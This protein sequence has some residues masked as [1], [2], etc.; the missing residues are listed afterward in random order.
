MTEKSEFATKRFQAQG[1]MS[2]KDTVLKLKS[3]H[4]KPVKAAEKDRVPVKRRNNRKRESIL[5]TD[6]RHILQLRKE[7][8][9]L[10][11][12]TVIIS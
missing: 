12:T 5:V 2:M 3:T 4:T 6:L 10:N 8:R 11:I 7:D 9:Y 1:M